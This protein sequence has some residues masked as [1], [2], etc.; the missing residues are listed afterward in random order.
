[1]LHDDAG[2]T[3]LDMGGQTRIADPIAGVQWF[4]DP[5]GRAYRTDMPDRPGGDA[6]TVRSRSVGDDPPQEPFRELPTAADAPEFVRREP[7]EVDGVPTEVSLYRQTIPE[8][9]MGN[10]APVVI[11]SEVHKASFGGLDGLTLR[12]VTRN[13]LAGKTVSE[14]RNLRVLT[15]DE[16]DA[17]FRPADDWTV[18]QAP[19]GLREA[20][21][22][23]GALSR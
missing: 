14:M 10:A 15:S 7:G 23:A 3:R 22:T 8:G 18:V 4:V 13:P 6:G 2:R 1:M 12:T 19:P 5:A 11:E 9:T 21:G 17:R 16:L 20:A